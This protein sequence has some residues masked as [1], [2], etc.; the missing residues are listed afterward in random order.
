MAFPKLYEL[1]AGAVSI[2]V[3][4]GLITALAHLSRSRGRKAELELYSAWGGKPTTVMLRHSD[5]Q[6]DPITKRRYHEFLARNIA[7]WSAPSEDDELRNLQKADQAYE[8]AVRWLLEHTRDQTRYA[9]L[10]RENIS[11]GFRR[12]CY[13]IKW[14]AMLIALAPLLAIGVDS[15]KIQVLSFGLNPMAA[16]ISAAL[17][18]VLLL[19]WLLV[20]NANWVKDAATAYATRLL[21]ACENDGRT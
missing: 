12:N 13:S 11:Y 1:L 15:F 9:L 10:F 20:V 5:N 2:F 16:L 3:V 18:L 6:L 8:S 21:A 14:L 17:S 4:F 7:G 19:W